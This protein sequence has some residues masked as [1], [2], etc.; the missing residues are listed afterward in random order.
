[1]EAR[2][3]GYHVVVSKNLGSFFE[4]PYT[5]EYSVLGSILVSPVYGGP[6][7]CKFRHSSI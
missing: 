1:M 7:A 4:S 5:K 6:H 2:S 3:L